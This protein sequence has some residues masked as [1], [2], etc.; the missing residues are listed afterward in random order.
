MKTKRERV[1]LNAL[2]SLFPDNT[3]GRNFFLALKGSESES[4]EEAK[5]CISKAV[6]ALEY[7]TRL[8]AARFYNKPV[9]KLLPKDI[10]AFIE[11]GL[12][13]S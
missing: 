5:K 1:N 7:R 8:D 10:D 9:S 3:V 4:H 11:Q 13:F 12:S 6:A 2:A